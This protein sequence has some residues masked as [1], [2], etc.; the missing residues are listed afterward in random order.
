MALDAHSQRVAELEELL[1]EKV[2]IIEELTKSNIK[3][4]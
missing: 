1:E 3:L 2:K 4:S